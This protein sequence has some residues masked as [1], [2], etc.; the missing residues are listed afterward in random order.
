ML[1]RCTNHHH[2]R[3]STG[4][5]LR[6]HPLRRRRPWTP[7]GL[8]PRVLLSGNPTY[9][10]VNLTSDTGA[11]SGTD[12]T[13]GDPSGD[14][15]WAIEQANANPNPA[16]SVINFDPT[17]FASPQTIMLS[18]TLELS[19]SAGP[20]VIDASTVTGPVT[21][22]G[23]DSV[24]VFLVDSNVTATLSDL[25][26]SD[27]SGYEGGGIDNAGTLTVSDSVIENCSAYLAGGGVYG[28]GAITVTGS[29]IA[30]NN[31][32]L[33]SGGGI[34]SGGGL[35]ISG[36]TIEGNSTP[37]DGGGIF[38]IG[39]AITDSIVENNMST[40]G[41]GGGIRAYDS[42]TIT[43]TVIQNNSAAGYGGG[44][45]DDDGAA[46]VIGSTIMG[47]TA[48]GGG[49]IFSFFDTM[50]IAGS[51]IEGNTAGAGGGVENEG[52]LTITLSTV[53]G[54]SSSYYGGG[55]SNSVLY[56]GPSATISDCTITHNTGNQGGGI[57]NGQG[58][59]TV[60]VSTIAANSAV[61]AGGI[62][63][64]GTATVV[65][66]TIAGNSS[67][68]I[69]NSG[70]L[71]A[72]N[73][74]IAYNSG[75]GGIDTSGTVT[76]GNTI[77]AA[78][79]GSQG[80][81]YDIDG[82]ANSETGQN[83]L[84]GIDYTGS[85]TNGLSGNIVFG[86]GNPGLGSL[87]Y[88]NGAST[89]TIALLAGSPAIDAGS[90]DIA[91][92]TVPSTDQTGEAWPGGA[93]SIGACGYPIQPVGTPTV[94]TVTD[95]SDN[96]ADTGS[97]RY[98]LAQAA[99]DGNPAGNVIQFAIPTTD[100]NYDPATGSW[101]ITLNPA[102]GPLQLAA[103]PLQIEG[104][105]AGSLTISGGDQVEVFQV[106]AGAPMTISGLTIAD[107]SASNGGG[108]SV[109]YG[110]TL[111]VNA[112]T[113]EDNTAD[114][115]GG[116]IDNAGNLTVAG[117]TIIEGNSVSATAYAFGGGVFNFGT[118]A[119]TGASTVEDNTSAQWGG[120]VFSNG[121]LTVNGGS[122]I[123][124]NTALVAGGGTGLSGGD[125]NYVLYTSA[126]ITD[127]AI[128][129]NSASSTES[130]YGGGAIWNGSL[131]GP[132]GTLT[133]TDST[134]ADN[135]SLSVAGGVQNVFGANC[136]ITDSTISGNSA[137]SAAGG[138]STDA[139]TLTVVGCTIENNT[140]AEAGGIGCGETNGGATLTV[141]DSTITGN[142]A[143]DGLGGGLL[144]AGTSATVTG[145]TISGNTASGAGGG[146]ANYSTATLTGCTISGNSRVGVW[147]DG[148]LTV[149]NC[150]IDFNADNGLINYNSGVATLLNTT[151]ANNSVSDGGVGGGI[152]SVGVLAAINVTIAYN[153]AASGGGL[154]IGAGDAL[155]DNSIV[156]A[157][158]PDDVSGVPN[159]VTGQYNLIGYDDTGS[160]INGTDGNQVGVTNPGLVPTLANNGGPTETI[161][162]EAGSPAIGTGMNGAGGYTLF[163]D[164][165]G[166]VPPAG[167]WDIGAYQYDGVPPAAPTA[168][169]SAANV[170][171]ANYG[172]TTYSFSI[173]FAS[174]AAIKESTLAGALVQ[175]VPPSGV[176]ASIT[177]S[178][179]ST[180]PN[181]PTDPFGNAQSFTITYEI[182]PP[183]SSWSP[184]DNGT[185]SVTLDGSPVTDVDGTAIAT[186]NIG[187]F[188]VQ[189]VSTTT[190]LEASADPSV[191]GESV[192]FT[193]SV[194]STISGSGTLGGT[195]QFVIDGSDFG[196]PVTLVNGSATSAAISTLS[197]ASHAIRA[198][199]SGSTVFQ[200]STGS[201]T[202]TVNQDSTTTSVTASAGTSSFGQ[203]ITFTATVTA[204]AP[205]SGIPTGTVDFVDTTTGNDLTP[206][207]VALASGVATFSISSLS[208][209]T[210]TIKATYSGNTDFLTSSASTGTIT[211][212]QSIVVL[213]P[214]AGGALS[215]AG[216]AS[217]S[218]AGGVFVDSSSSTA[219][220][221]SGNAA[222]KASVIDV[223]GKVSKSGNA[224]FSPSPVTGAAVLA[225]P[226]ASLAEP[227]TSGL[228]NCGSESLSGNSSATIKP[229][230]YSGISVSGNAALT[231]SSGTYVI[232]GGGF[233]VSGN[234]S[235][236]GSGVM[237]V[238]AG[239]KYPSTGGTYG[240]ITF[241]GN[242]SY[243]LTPLASGAYA[244]IVIFQSRD[245]SDALT[246]SGN[247]SGMTGTVYAP[248]AQLSESGN[249][250]LNAAV[251]A[252]TVTISGNG[253]N[254]A[255]TLNAPSGT[256]AYTPAQVRTAYGISE[257]G[258]DGTG[259]TIAIVDA[260]DDT[261][262]FQS[263]D[264]FDNQFGLNA[265]GPTLY[266]QYGPASSFLMVL[267]Q[268]GQGTSLP[269]TDPNGPG[270]DNWEVEE[271]LDVEWA[272]A[273]APGAQIILVE[274][275]S[276]SLSDLMAS[277]ATAA[278]QPGVSVVSI[279]WGFPEGQAVFAADEAAYD[280]VFN[281]PGVTFV[282]STGDYGAADPEY[283]AFSPNVLA[284]GGTSLTL[285]ALGSYNSETGWGYY[286]SSAGAS[287][288]SG[289]GVSLYETEPA[290]QEG[291]QS[292]G[293]RT[294]PDVSLVADPA[295]G[296]WIADTYNLDPS[297][298]FQ[299][300]GG[301][302]LS[303]P[304]WAGLVSLVN[305]G[306]AAAGETTLNSTSPTD[307]QQALYILPQSDY[308][309]IT[310]GNNG[311]TA[312]AGY[313][314]VTGLGTPVANLLVPDLI[315]YQ[316]ASTTYS[317]STV[318]PLQ[319]SVLVNSG[320]TDS[321]PMD[322]FSVFDSFT[323]TNVGLSHAHAKGSSQAESA[324]GHGTNAAGRPLA[325]L[326]EDSLSEIRSAAAVDLGQ[327]LTRPETAASS[328]VDQVLGVLLDANSYD[329]V[330]GDLA[331]EQVS[332]GVRKP[333]GS[334][335]I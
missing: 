119:I 239:S 41:D 59:L 136:T 194:A 280:S 318:A 109:N 143:S 264:A 8:E 103:G 228:T 128:E 107:G 268:Y 182:T 20:E 117:A 49:G 233:S 195:I 177:A 253:V 184:A 269:S 5:L 249:A 310:S 168:A 171:P 69:L 159:S 80:T 267:N 31:A 88:N 63:N 234:A 220:S 265:S 223:H 289:G 199:Y 180:V 47:N 246:I 294:T 219:L 305:Q 153:S 29:T 38:A 104:P 37:G 147:N 19:G 250:Q 106:D 44:M 231:L 178:V 243:R 271:S 274:A 282:A 35:T 297:N 1:G 139:G 309:A 95:T 162:L 150:A 205:G 187:S 330:I 238:N 213:D 275:N 100:P 321:G 286:S 71:A 260:Y 68:G 295:T 308:N 99:T 74:T 46:T 235:V 25:T 273:I 313:N 30:N 315:A 328:A 3:H 214:S 186:G 193:A 73:D 137:V 32:T 118:L 207:G 129:G 120:G 50:S 58:A 97:L 13:T 24:G 167:V 23:N 209:G 254:N 320:T 217:I 218:L 291:V 124:N 200:G 319:N 237:I 148:S 203:S 176:G 232:E 102:N 48:A 123:D 140:A 245:N 126:T 78:N 316:G 169:L 18:S 266:Q 226:L 141:I 79:T 52:T 90:A 155:L 15:L 12:A 40:D 6:G 116:G 94:Y 60:S 22:S 57:F 284:V 188:A 105:G 248:A 160:F 276:Q 10:T 125:G 210:H 173:A 287:I 127:A 317:G 185:Y 288:G 7:E 221:A 145:C 255:V 227:S 259:Q 196:S 181:G 43:G 17:V 62:E 322:V 229:G 208:V 303:A 292:L 36:S 277:V 285:S 197:A 111:T 75:G 236:T 83:N 166:Y 132:T 42:L 142:T 164:Q 174:N 108:I 87:A 296:A 224:S 299:V 93:V 158:T 212:N 175:V 154:F 301:T 151:I 311:Y 81:P 112:C 241:S 222:V 4:R 113:I 327:P 334:A 326:P 256:V 312:S 335:A 252:D 192:T 240:S 34:Y 314:L 332:S 76:M 283:P 54:N 21:I 131:S 65:D 244:G 323:V 290:Y 115:W 211:I 216:N 215:L 258:L 257:L 14:L 302:S 51:T 33:S 201:L 86:P 270:T 82:V 77:V 134:I 206:G 157:N 329:A 101:T 165:R 144:I 281:V 331:F 272:H 114:Y 55:I 2:Q 156:A 300:V 56:P 324:L 85:F 189:G 45:R 251:V 9:Y 130:I 91:G 146:I 64:D 307:T 70:T 170:T 333:R 53:T 135:S 27:G 279:S 96:P 161:A 89:E 293:M 67:G 66:T 278:A 183:G 163:T 247:A 152:Y 263:V 225:D 261:N 72:V 84:I 242:G 179:V 121:I 61:G 198:L 304:A 133:I 230:I 172:Q 39:A 202:Q 92:V 191:F 26:I 11:S 306:R 262:I 122:T 190:T 110:A 138:L 149:S 298:P 98:A 28:S 16:G 204:N 325:N